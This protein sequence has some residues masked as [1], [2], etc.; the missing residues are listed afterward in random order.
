MS[1]SLQNDNLKIE[2]LQNLTGG[3]IQPGEAHVS[4][5]LSWRAEMASYKLN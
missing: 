1:T 4:N 2:L 5:H 3:V